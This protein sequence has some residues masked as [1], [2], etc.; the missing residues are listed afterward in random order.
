[1]PGAHPL[2]DGRLMTVTAWVI[3]VPLKSHSKRPIPPGILIYTY[4]FLSKI[5]VQA[6]VIF[7]ASQGLAIP[8]FTGYRYQMLTG[9][10]R[11]WLTKLHGNGKPAGSG[12]FLAVMSRY[13]NLDRE[14]RTET[15]SRGTG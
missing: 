3:P 11:C 2:P 9:V 7:I 13:T 12:I 10:V 4:P 5:E 6:K 8:F 14:P 1:M 15:F